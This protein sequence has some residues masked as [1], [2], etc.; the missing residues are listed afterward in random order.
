MYYD[1]VTASNE[2]TLTLLNGSFGN[3]VN[4]IKAYYVMDVPSHLEKGAN[5]GDYNEVLG[6][7][8]K[9]LNG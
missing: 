5:R 8:E 7:V 4:N 2:P 1:C 9:L 3:H 6:E